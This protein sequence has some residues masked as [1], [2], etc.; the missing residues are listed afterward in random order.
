[1][2]S[3]Q[4]NAPEFDPRRS[5]VNWAAW[6]RT[7]SV[8][9]VVAIVWVALWRMTPY[10]LTESNL[11]NLGIQASN[12]AIIAAGLTIVLIVAE[13][14]LSIGA[15]Q[16]LAGSAA[17]V[18]II[19][20]SLPI[21]LGI[22]VALAIGVGAG[23]ANG[24]LSW[25]LR[26]PSFIATLA[27]LGIAQGIAYVATNNAPINGFPNDYLSIGTGRLPAN[28]P[29]PVAIAILMIIAADLVLNHTRL[30]RHIYAV[31][32]NAESARLSGINIGRVKL[33]ALAIS[34]FMAG[35]GGIILSSR[36]NAG[37]GD[38]GPED[39]L[40]AV[41]AVVI[42]GTSL[43]GG[44]GSIWATTGGVLL[45]VTITNGLI[46]LNVASQ[47]QQIVVGLIII[48]AMLIDQLIKGDAA[49]TLRRLAQAVRATDATT[50]PHL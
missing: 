33:Y 17:A 41:A 23:V 2:R 26:I 28:F 46:L 18:A 31:G 39:L 21:W 8:Y 15:L 30:G 29:V 11:Y 47:W 32:G 48:G 13:I 7:A 27:M 35:L 1:V 22:A 44:T 49:H 40:P 37:S 45:L 10:F 24:L 19:H 9:G 4:N 6:I 3:R 5:R 42:G 25:K 16:A 34:G 38:F 50:R 12:L 43:F 14:D 36:L 20:D